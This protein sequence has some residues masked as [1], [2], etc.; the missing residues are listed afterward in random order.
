MVS[1]NELIKRVS[2]KYDIQLSMSKTSNVINTFFEILKQHLI[3]G[4][5]VQI[6]DFG[7]FSVVERKP[8]AHIN[9]VTGEKVV[10]P[11]HKV[12]VFKPYPK[13]KKEVK[14]GFNEYAWWTRIKF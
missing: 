6:K 1:K 3:A 11:A 5:T 7:V 4:E 2:E 10:N 14:E 8:K 12:P 9:V 13:L